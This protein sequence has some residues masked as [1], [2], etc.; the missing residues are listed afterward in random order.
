MGRVQTTRQLDNLEWFITTLERIHYGNGLLSNSCGLGFS[1]VKV[2][3]FGCTGVC[4]MLVAV[5]VPGKVTG[6]SGYRKMNG[7]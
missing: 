3:T 2:V 7:R 1:R 6:W 5:V 4:F